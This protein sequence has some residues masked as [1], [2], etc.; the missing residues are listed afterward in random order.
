MGIATKM[1]D[2]GISRLFSGE[3]VSKAD[4]RLVC[5]GVLDVLTSQMGLARSL[6]ALNIINE[7]LYLIQNDLIILG[8]ELATSKKAKKAGPKIGTKQLTRLDLW[9]KELET[10]LPKQTEF[11]IPGATPAS[12]ALHLSR[13]ICRHLESHIV[14]LF[15]DGELTNKTILKYINRLSDLLHIFSRFEEENGG[16]VVISCTVSSKQDADKISHAL[17]KKKLAACVQT[18]EGITSTYFW[19]KKFCVDKEFLLIIKTRMKRMNDVIKELKR[20]HTYEIPEIIATPIIKGLPDYIN[21]LT[22]NTK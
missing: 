17:V 20:L 8:A 19:K 21:W 12:S 14:A 4:P 22:E 6:S 5:Y 1:G 15:E 18:I 10:K 16:F 3:G 11:I 2:C 9:L 13:T 7:R